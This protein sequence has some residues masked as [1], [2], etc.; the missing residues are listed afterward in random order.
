MSDR[1][2]VWVVGGYTGGHTLIKMVG[3]YTLIKTQWQKSAVSQ[4]NDSYQMIFEKLQREKSFQC[5]NLVRTIKRVAP[6]GV[7]EYRFYSILLCNCVKI[8]Q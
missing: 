4:I 1:N 6:H 3:G 2:S 5:M 7:C 8:V